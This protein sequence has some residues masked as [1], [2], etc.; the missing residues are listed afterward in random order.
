MN[1]RNFLVGVGST[2]LG[3]S[4]LLASGAFSRVESTRAVSIQVAPDPDAYLGMRPIETPNSNNYVELDE[5][6][7]LTIDIGENPNGG[8]GVNSD[9]RT[10]FD[11]LFELCNN[12]KEDACLS[13]EFGTNF[14]RRENAELVFYYD[15]DEDADPTTS[16]RV[17]VEEGRAVLLPVGECVIVGLRTETFSVDA[18]ED[19]PLFDGNIQLTATVDGDCFDGG[20]DEGEE[21]ASEQI[22]VGDAVA[23]DSYLL[24]ETNHSTH[25]RVRFQLTNEG[26]IPVGIEGLRLESTN[27]DAVRASSYWEHDFGMTTPEVLFEGTDADG[28]AIETDGNPN[29]SVFFADENRSPPF[30]GVVDDTGFFGSFEV[31]ETHPPGDFYPFDIAHAG[32]WGDPAHAGDEG[33]ELRS[34][35][36]QLLQ[37]G[38]TAVVEI[39]EFRKEGVVTP[40]TVDMSGQELTV[41]LLFTD[42]S[43]RTLELEEIGAWELAESK[44]V[45]Y[46]GIPIGTL[47]LYEVPFSDTYEIRNNSAAGSETLF[48]NITGRIDWD[49]GEQTT[50]DIAPFGV[51]QIEP[52]EDGGP[53][54]IASA[55]KPAPD[56]VIIEETEEV[57]PAH[58]DGEIA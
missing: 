24:P 5:K 35:N 50:F 2:A 7:H 6:G 53:I 4:A 56:A 57:E 22:A 26:S 3:G 52:P 25:A 19:G 48:A 42:G 14:E 32:D 20:D 45:T 40:N 12:G 47:E 9:S 21:E 28:P 51:K 39:G 33:G 58:S 37:A 41:S 13:W 17:D 18:T 44:T 36:E 38:E 8:Q 10:W 15:G 46:F 49:N 23:R 54:G 55:E 34:A 30:A 29:V 31:N 43:E 1:R 27:T 11:G 16:G